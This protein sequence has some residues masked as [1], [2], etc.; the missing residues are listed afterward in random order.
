VTAT[1]R[2]PTPSRGI[3]YRTTGALFLALVAAILGAMPG[4]KMCFAAWLAL[5]WVVLGC[6]VMSSAFLA[7]FAAM[8]LDFAALR[9]EGRQILNLV[10]L[11][12]VMLP[13]GW[14]ST[15]VEFAQARPV[16]QAQADV[17]ARAGG[18]RLAMTPASDADWPMPTAGFVYDVDGALSRPVSRRPAAWNDSPVLAAL[19]SECITVTRFVGDYYRWS[20]ACGG[21]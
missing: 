20:S 17:S 9:G 10:L 15:G 12:L 4:W 8:S 19:T 14:L 13:M 2:A 6:V 16:L 7:M 18:P 3:G 1:A 11:M 5:S 21:P